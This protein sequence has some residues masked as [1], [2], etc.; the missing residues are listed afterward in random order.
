MKIKYPI[1]NVN[2]VELIT[3][4]TSY[5]FSTITIMYCNC[6]VLDNNNHKTKNQHQQFDI[7]QEINCY[8]IK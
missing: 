2:A 4:K 8:E 6:S 3:L 5:I 1:A 7:Q